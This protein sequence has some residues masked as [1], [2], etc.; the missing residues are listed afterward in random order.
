[1]REMSIE[2]LGEMLERKVEEDGVPASGSETIVYLK[3]K[4]EKNFDL[5]KEELEA[6]KKD[7]GQQVQMFQFMQ[8]QLQQQ[9]QQ[10]V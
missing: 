3:E 6:R 4:A 10:Q 7:Q 5:R 9:Q 2:K 8:Q 1:M